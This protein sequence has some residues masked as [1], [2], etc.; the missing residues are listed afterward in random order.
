MRPG[1]PGGEARAAR[2]RAGMS[3]A[4]IARR[5]GTSTVAVSRYETN[6]PCPAPAGGAAAYE[7]ALGLP[8]G[9]LPARPPVQLGPPGRRATAATAAPVAAESLA[10]RLRAARLAAGLSCAELGS[11]LGV[12]RER[13][14]QW[15]RSERRAN[16]RAAVRY[17]EALGLPAGTLVAFAPAPHVRT[18]RTKRPGP[19]ASPPTA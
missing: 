18:H 8:A 10:G 17:E 14:S 2:L 11:L 19:R 5:L 13:V 3:L 9:T 15:E 6:L 4:E 7:R 1:T 12:S 16:R